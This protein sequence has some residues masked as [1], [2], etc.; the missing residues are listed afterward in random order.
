[1]IHKCSR[2]GQGK[3]VMHL[4]RWLSKRFTPMTMVFGLLI[5]TNPSKKRAKC[6]LD[7]LLAEYNG[8]M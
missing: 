6:Q 7:V 2:K 3:R 1:M 8:S 5:I 4:W